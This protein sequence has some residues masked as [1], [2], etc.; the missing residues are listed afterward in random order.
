MIDAVLVLLE[1]NNKFIFGKRSLKK[2]SLPGVWSIPS[3]KKEENETIYETAKREVKEELGL[4]IYDVS[5]FDKVF[6][7]KDNEKKTLY[8]M[9]AK[10]NGLPKIIAK[11]ELDELIFLS[12]EDLFKKYEDS[13]IGHG[14]QY[15]RKKWC[16]MKVT[17]IHG[18][19]AT[20]EG[21]WFPWVKQKLVERGIEVEIPIMPNTD[22]PKIIPW[23]NKLK[24]LGLNE[25]TVIIGHS[26]GCQ[27]IL[28]YL[29]QAD[30][31]IKKAILVSP[32]MTIN[33]NNCDEEEEPWEIAQPWA[34]TPIDF[35]KI[36]DKA[37]E[38]VVIYSE[39]DPYAI[40]EDVDNLIKVLNAKEV[41]VGKKG[42]IDTYAGI[43]E[44]PEV[45]KEI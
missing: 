4:D 45:L 9:K 37:E 27:T 24:E 26:V 14:L 43:T 1:K 11:D 30:I 18:W 36:K 19:G 40:K 5:L 3:G 33:K 35:N 32:W 41:N 29:E 17:I 16:D 39:D 7:D 15:L 13:K 6:I 10:Y 42:H 21:D 28:R 34:E 23:V 38:F 31:K 20:P 22:E 12:L 25:E 8:F 44:L 2:E